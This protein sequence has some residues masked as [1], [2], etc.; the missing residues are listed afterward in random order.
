MK[1]PQSCA[2]PSIYAVLCHDPDM[3]E[4]LQVLLVRRI[5]KQILSVL[6]SYL[7]PVPIITWAA[8]SKMLASSTEPFVTKKAILNPMY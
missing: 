3:L 6:P 2:K 8:R 5:D 1:F 7:L 4:P